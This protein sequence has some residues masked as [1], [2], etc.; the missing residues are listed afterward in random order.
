MPRIDSG[1]LQA[2]YPPT[3]ARLHN[4]L[5]ANIAVEGR[6]E[7]VFVKLFCHG[8]FPFDQPSLLEEPMRR[9]LGDLLELANQNKDFSVHFATARE[10]FNI[11]MA[12]IDGH[13][14]APGIHRDYSLRLI[15]Q[16]AK[17]LRSTLSSNKIRETE[18]GAHHIKR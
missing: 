12:A 15:M 14:G 13:N 1:S 9:F 8:F 3:L 7:W 10:A 17:T 16:T 2:N 4:W 6:P 11:A 5:G 18:N